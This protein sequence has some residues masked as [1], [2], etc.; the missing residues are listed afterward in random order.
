ME[1]GRHHEARDILAPA[2]ARFT[3]GFESSDLKAAKALLDELAGHS[4]S[5]LLARREPNPR[6]S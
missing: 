5:E 1:Q 6:A 3:E 4:P 2:Y